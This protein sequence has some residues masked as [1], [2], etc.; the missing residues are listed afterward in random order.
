MEIE[1]TV[2]DAAEDASDVAGAVED[3][4]VTVAK[5]TGEVSLIAA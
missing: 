5:L 1:R 2:G 4:E 3:T